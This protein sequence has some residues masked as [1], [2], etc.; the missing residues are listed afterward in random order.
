MR[1]KKQMLSLCL[2]AVMILGSWTTP[3][4]VYAA[5]LD[6]TSKAAETEQVIHLKDTY[7]E[8]DDISGVS[9]S[10]T[11]VT[12]TES[13]EY[14]L[15]GTLT[16]GQI[17]VASSNKKDEIIIYLTNVSVTCSTGNAFNATKGCVTLTNASGSTSSFISTYADSGIGIY[18]KN[19]LTIKGADASTKIIAKSTAGNGIRCKSD[20]EIGAG[21]LEVEAGNHGIKGDESVK[22]TKK[23]GTIK[24]TAAGDAIKTDAIDEDTLEIETNS[25]FEP[26]GVITINGGTFDL[27]SSTGDGIQAD[28]GLIVSNAPQI[29]IHSAAE[30]IKVNTTPAEA[31]YYTDETATSTETV[32]G[33]IQI[34][35]GTFN[36]MSGED[37]IKAADY[38]NITGGS[39][40]ID[41]K[42]DGIQSGVDYVNDNGET[43]Y[44]NGN[45]MITNGVFDITSND[46]ISGNSTTDSC[47]GIKASNN[48]TIQGGTFD[49]NCY[50]DAIH[51][52]YNISITGGV[53]DIATTDDGVHADYYL[54]MGAENGTDDDY[55]MNISTSY[56]GL[57]A[58][59][60]DY[61]SGTTTLYAT[62]DG[63]NAAGDYEEN[64]TYHG[65]DS[66]SSSG[67]TGW[68]NWRPGGGFG[69][70]PNQGFEDN[71][72]Y[73]MIYIKGG[74]LYVVAD[75]D[76]LDSNGSILMSNGVVV[77]N[78]T[79]K[80]GNGVFD[81][82]DKS[83]D[84]FTVT[85][86]TLVGFGTTD[87]Q[88]NPTVTGQGYFKTTT[89]FTKG[90]LKNVQLSTGIYM[91]I[92]PEITLSS[93]LL[94]V[95]TP[96]MTSGSGS[97]YSGNISF[98]DVDK[99]L[100]RTVNNNFYG[101]YLL[102]TNNVIA[103]KINVS[104]TENGT[105]T[106]GSSEYNAGEKVAIS[107]QPEDGYELS[108]I[109]I[110]DKNG[111][112]I[113][114]DEND[115]VYSFTMPKSNVTVTAKFILKT[116]EINFELFGEGSAMV[117]TADPKAGDVITVILEADE[118]YE[119]SVIN[120][121]D[122]DGKNVALRKEEGNY[123]FVMPESDVTISVTYIKTV[124]MPF[125][126]VDKD[127]Y[128]YAAVQWAVENNITKGVTDT[129]FCPDNIC[130]RAQVAMFLWRNAGCPDP[131]NEKNPF[132][133]V[134]TK[135]QF[136]N[137]IIWAYE[138][139]ITVG[140]GD[141]TFRPDDQ[142]RRI[143]YITFQWRAAGSPL[144]AAIVM[145]FNDVEEDLYPN[146]INAVLWAYENE[147]TLGKD[148]NFM[149][150][151]RCSRGDVVTFLYRTNHLTEH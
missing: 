117:Y 110:T 116:Y 14:Y 91:G 137:A 146:Y 16:D 26:K 115:G 131:V 88:D 103:Y 47:K 126:D 90:T 75:G 86:G 40:T 46:G 48:L 58:S 1:M 136:Y 25:S 138:N 44:T 49:L 76:G 2:T 104:D 139:G 33:Y 98:N 24:V 94:F 120:I 142:V 68:S 43:V 133:D 127:K 45:L 101:I 74:C 31:W 6:K 29:T 63:V 21:D 129:T 64:G 106:V 15:E 4:S 108:E 145:P 12:I 150:E 95:T 109:T 100:G 123:V 87:M 22:F 118:G 35:G 135:S 18:S 111:K 28:Y 30:G 122:K 148:N 61:L 37:G 17:V 128:Y 114:L 23:A 78:G 20:L 38:I 10:G 93:A 134:S 13:G 34:N 81:K 8:A 59:V 54:T 5:E 84:S 147:I 41:A 124:K 57:E 73:G 102:D 82:G 66:S 113:I 77:V 42:Q 60:I 62:D 105:V 85:G 141:G 92:V 132:S 80:G 151:V 39:I 140:Y 72:D 121:T 69:G 143:E 65:S 67:N 130:T 36:I 53:F 79:T 107:V 99:I 89:G 52:N 112:N 125:V 51:S 119:L 144:S 55:T 83:G 9:V 19:D 32:Q 56:E 96:E 149:P 3:L 50:D 71:S 70:G 27:I 11:T 7:V 97:V